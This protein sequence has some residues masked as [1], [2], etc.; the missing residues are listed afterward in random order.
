M[1]QLNGTSRLAH[2]VLTRTAEWPSHEP[3][4]TCHVTGAQ[5]ET[6]PLART[7]SATVTATAT[8]PTGYSRPSNP[9]RN[10]WSISYVA[11]MWTRLQF[12]SRPTPT[13]PPPPNQL[14]LGSE[15]MARVVFGQPPS[16]GM[17][18][19]YRSGQRLVHPTGINAHE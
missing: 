17:S 8:R 4:I 9:F 11:T 7:Q 3:L 19:A 6:P 16:S 14:A 15:M 13:M 1:R 10:D 18:C 12:G 5:T 2:V